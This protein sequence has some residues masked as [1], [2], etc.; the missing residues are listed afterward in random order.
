MKTQNINFILSTLLSLCLLIFIS[1]CGEKEKETLESV[2]Q[3]AEDISTDTDLKIF[4]VKSGIVEYKITGYEVGKKILYFDNYGSKT[5]FHMDTK[6]DDEINKGWIVSKGDYQYMFEPSRSNEGLKIENP[7]MQWL[8]ESSGGDMEKFSE[9]MYTKLGMKK[10]GTE[11]FLGKE[12]IVYRGD[13]GKVLIW[14]GILILNVTMIGEEV[15]RQEAT[16][17]KVNVPIDEK[18]FEIP[19]NI[20]FSEMPGFGTGGYDEEEEDSG[21][22]DEE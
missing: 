6:S 3:T 10:A 22:E 8:K 21:Y 15:S 14:N 9:E 12:C 20:K 4:K 17:I 5:A 18:Y 19:K 7:F 1:S 13:M 11:N 16:S 2:E